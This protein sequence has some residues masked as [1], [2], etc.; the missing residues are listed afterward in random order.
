MTYPAWIQKVGRECQLAHVAISK[1]R[2]EWHDMARAEAGEQRVFDLLFY[3]R[4]LT[5]AEAKAFEE[6]TLTAA[7][8][9]PADVTDR[10]DVGMPRNTCAFYFRVEAP[11]ADAAAQIGLTITRVGLREAGITLTVLRFEVEER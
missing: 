3:V 4:P 2:N 1:I 8:Y 5:H 6:A 11:T 10:L 7:G 9:K